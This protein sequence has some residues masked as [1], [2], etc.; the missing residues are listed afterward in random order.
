MRQQIDVSL[1]VVELGAAEVFA[2]APPAQPDDGV[3]GREEAED[4]GEAR[5]KRRGAREGAARGRA[6]HRPRAQGPGNLKFSLCDKPAQTRVE[7]I[8]LD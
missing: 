6:P 3:Q 5:E 4:E 8:K 1:L 2:P 7:R